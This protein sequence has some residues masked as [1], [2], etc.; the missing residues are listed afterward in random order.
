MIDAIQRM[1]IFRG[2]LGDLSG[3]TRVAVM[4]TPVTLLYLIVSFIKKFI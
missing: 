4:S 3:P 1:C 2:A